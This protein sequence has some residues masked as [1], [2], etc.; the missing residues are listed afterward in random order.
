[1]RKVNGK[2]Q[3]GIIDVIVPYK[4]NKIDIILLYILRSNTFQIQQ[5]IW[6]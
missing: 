2:P 4:N 5:S 3:K 1:M 6:Q